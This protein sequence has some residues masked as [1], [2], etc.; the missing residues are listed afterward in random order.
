MTFWQDARPATPRFRRRRPHRPRRHGRP[1]SRLTR[2]LVVGVLTVGVVAAIAVVRSDG[3]AEAEPGRTHR[4]ERRTPAASTAPRRVLPAWQAPAAD[5][6]RTLLPD[7]PDV[8]AVA[9][10]H[11]R[12]Y[13]IADGKRLWSTKV[14]RPLERADARGFTVLIATEDS[15]MSLDRATGVVRWRVRSPEPPG[16]VALVGSLPGSQ[17]AIGATEAGGLVGIDGRSGTA[18][19]SVRYPGRVI[20]PMTVARG[21]ELLASVWATADDDGGVLRVVDGRTGTLRWEQP[22]ARSAGAPAIAGGL[23][24]VSAGDEQGSALRAFGLADGRERWSSRVETPSQPDLVP[25]VD[26]DAVVTVDRGGTVVAVRTDDGTREWATATGALTTYAR[27]IRVRDAVL[28]WNEEGEVVTLD[29]AT[30]AVRARRLTPGVA[31]G[32]VADGDRVVVG[33]RMIRG[34]PVQAFRAP[35]LAA[36]ARSRR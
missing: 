29:R 5:W 11:V 26:G 4:A 30:G 21:S 18:V 13:R 3:H 16:P 31:I 20:A 15:F 34:A 35:E 14:P 9:D 7:G 2:N 32:L 36:P 24:V 27:P 8:I 23:V 28:L 17:L 12:A 22:I 1:R 6:P 10:H 25:L 33:L 19:W